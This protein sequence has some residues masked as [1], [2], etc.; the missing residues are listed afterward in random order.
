[1]FDADKD[2]LSPSHVPKRQR[3]AANTDSTRISEAQATMSRQ[4][5]P[6][7]KTDFEKEYLKNTAKLSICATRLFVVRVTRWKEG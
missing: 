4:E 3:A 7:R 1:M 5:P 6:N 2:V